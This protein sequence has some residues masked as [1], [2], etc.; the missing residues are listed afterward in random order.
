MPLLMRAGIGAK[1]FGFLCLCLLLGLAVGIL[2]FNRY[3]HVANQMSRDIADRTGDLAEALKTQF[4][5]NAYMTLGAM[6][7]FQRVQGMNPKDCS[8]VSNFFL[9][10]TNGF[11]N[12]GAASTDGKI[13]CTALPI[14]AGSSVRDRQW[15]KDALASG[16]FTMGKYSVNATTKQGYFMF[17]LPLKDAKGH[18]TQVL[19]LTAETNYLREILSL[20][21]LPTDTSI[22]VIDQFGN[23][24]ANN[25]GSF[26]A[27][28]NIAGW[29]IAKRAM[30]AD[31]AFVMRGTDR[32]GTTR[33]YSA[34]SS[35][36]ASTAV[37]GAE[38]ATIRAF[39]IIVG[40]PAHRITATVMAPFQAA[41]LT[42]V[43]VFIIIIIG[44]Y[45]FVNRT[46][47]RPIQEIQSAA[48]RLTFGDLTARVG[49][50][51]RSG[52]I[53]T[54]ADAFN[55]MA[56]TLAKREGDIR[57]S[58]T[59]FQ[60]I[61]DT[62]PASV[63]LLD[64]ELKVID[65]NQA[66]LEIFGADRIEDLRGEVV[67]MLVI[68]DDHARYREHL[69]AVRAG[70]THSI[71]V[72]I[73]D[74]KGRNRWV[75]MQ[76]A[77]IKLNDDAPTA[78][79]SIARDKTEELATAAQLVQAQKME[80]IGRLTG[81]V[82]H[83]FNNLLTVMMGNAEILRE[84][85]KEQPRLEKLAGMIESAAQRGAELTHRMLAFA[86]RQVLRPSE[87]DANAL[88]N[89][90][91]EMM[92]RLLG[93]DVRILIETSDEL[94]LV[95]ADSAQMES[96][97]LNLAINARD[98]MPTGGTLTIETRNVT[99]D[100]EYVARNPEA[101]AGDYVQ[102]AVSDSGTGMSHDTL[103]QVFDP[104]FTTK[105]V[106]K[107]TGLGLSMV[108][109]FVKQSQGHIK[110]YSE[111]SHGTT[112]RIY[113]PRITADTD[114]EGETPLSSVNDTSGTE[115][116]LVTEDEETVRA[117]V[118][119]Q[120]RSLGYVVIETSTAREALDILEKR[121]DIDLLFTDVVLPGDMNGR[122]LADL[123]CEKHPGLKVLYTTGYTENAVVHHGKLDAGVELLSKPY[124]R[125]DL[126][127]HIRKVLDKT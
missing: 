23:V 83:D 53:R 96:A 66:G 92:S 4:I 70:C 116:I 126:A 13:Y 39:S 125:A 107:G 38:Q 115:T 35:R 90:M 29:P 72:Q 56:A 3:T 86:R 73:V 20:P 75:E 79:I 80:S 100:E 30:T 82:A 109:G 9:T 12:I 10:N 63:T 108:Y 55:T 97:I 84:E 76:S 8:D 98:A 42:I 51:P 124:R 52:E 118:T 62:E 40:I 60:R 77:N 45:L 71:T 27:G 69:R 16:H 31:K 54:L 103:T 11:G 57:A 94:W 68:E 59:R 65:I 6:S 17:A 50:R 81:G 114:R 85:L 44:T 122:Q 28:E 88:L 64:S 101:I 119:E 36:V 41:G 21:H 74:L 58:N 67:P 18:I 14:A 95:S 93:E 105:E 61:F 91:I 46:L 7:G 48:E 121:N 89:R 43:I 15:F 26:D 33:L 113:L 106:G 112:I 32:N 78:Y 104:F 49:R 5:R 99:L 127:R 19:G 123:A 47:V 117:Y 87:L 22:T 110:I 102:I 2:A 34:T 25:G 1:V 24:M 37:P 120:L 111:V